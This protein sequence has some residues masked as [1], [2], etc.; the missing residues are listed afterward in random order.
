[1][2]S[3]AITVA[4]EVTLPT[5]EPRREDIPALIEGLEKRLAQLKESHSK[6]ESVLHDFESFDV[7]EEGA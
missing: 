4:Y 3:H 6:G 7:M 5:E 1:M 2:W